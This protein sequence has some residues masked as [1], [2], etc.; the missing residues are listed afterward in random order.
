MSEQYYAAACFFAM[1]CAGAYAKLFII[2]DSQHDS[3]L[4][5]KDYYEE[6][7][8][9]SNKNR[10]FEAARMPYESFIKF[11][12]LLVEHGKLEGSENI[13]A[14][15][16]ILMFMSSLTGTTLATQ[17]E[18]WQH[19]KSTCSTC[20][21]KVRKSLLKCKKWLYAK[22]N[23]LDDVHS[24]FSEKKF[25]PFYRPGSWKPIGALDGSHVLAHVSPELQEVFRN[26]KKW[27]SQNV[28]G[29]C[30]FDC[31]FS[32]ALFGWEGSA[33]DGR[34]VN[35]AFE[36]GLPRYDDQYYFGDAGYGLSKWILTP[37]RGVRYHLRQWIHG[38]Q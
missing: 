26:R 14:G 2:K 1:L 19:S 7:M 21:A 31:L 16:M 17:A 27:V 34:V 29:V 30:N 11:I 20:N 18:R 4:Q 36:K 35:S 3:K 37:Y 6:V 8:S 13:H 28:L 33:H 25:A 12:N 38:E 10:F 23:E 15:E 24:K 5:G 9:T 22:V 32:Y